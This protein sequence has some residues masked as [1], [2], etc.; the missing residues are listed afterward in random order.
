MSDGFR[1][2]LD[3]EALTLMND[4]D[5]GDGDAQYFFARYL[6]Y[7]EEMKPR[8]ELMSE[9]I[10]WAMGYLRKSAMSSSVGAA[11]AMSLG[12]IYSKGE[13]V[14][15]D[16]K[17]A[18]KW[19][20]TA[21]MSGN[22]VALCAL[23]D[24]A[25]EG[26]DSPDYRSAVDYY[27]RAAHKFRDAL[28]RLGDMFAQGHFFRRDGEMAR[29]LYEQV[30]ALEEE[31]YASQGYCSDAYDEVTQRLALLDENATC[32]PGENSPEQQEAI[33]R[34]LT[35]LEACAPEDERM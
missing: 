15:R 28:Y 18:R 22:P 34:I 9:E 4:A 7:D 30:L 29:R 3:R 19:Y 2:E 21:V 23:G 8:E 17:E 32:E 31:L 13:L 12:D 6:L 16:D 20:E 24:M 5:R 35:L 33:D 14:P 26:K 10:E 1:L 27:I 25:V 11:A